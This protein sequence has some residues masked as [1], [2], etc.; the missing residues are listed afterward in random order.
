[1]TTRLSR[2]VMAEIAVPALLSLVVIAFLAAGNELRER[3]DVIES[4]P[5]SRVGLC[6]GS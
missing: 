1:M 5:H 2:Y 4:R 3:S 6:S